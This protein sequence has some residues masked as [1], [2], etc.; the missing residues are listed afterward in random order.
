MTKFSRFIFMPHYSVKVSTA[1]ISTSLPQLVPILLVLKVSRDIKPTALH[2]AP[3]LA[4]YVVAVCVELAT[5]APR[6]VASILPFGTSRSAVWRVHPVSSFY[7][8]TLALIFNCFE[9]FFTLSS[10]GRAELC[11]WHVHH[12]IFWVC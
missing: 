9:D 5:V 7:T 11:E 1:Y 2:V 6:S 4:K 8:C 12:S 3:S 10:Y